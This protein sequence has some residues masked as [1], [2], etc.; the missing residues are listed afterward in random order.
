ML[1][2]RLLFVYLILDT[3]P[4]LTAESLWETRLLAGVCIV[5]DTLYKTP[6]VNQISP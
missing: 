4:D 6:R 1:E 5:S 2:T 3:F